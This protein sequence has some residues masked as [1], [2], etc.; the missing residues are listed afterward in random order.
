MPFASETSITRI[1]AARWRSG[2]HQARLGE[3]MAALIEHLHD[4]ARETQLTERE[5]FE[6]TEFL[7]RVGAISNEKRKEFILLSDTLGLSMLVELMN[8]CKPAGATEP[9]LLGP[10]YIPD[11]PR[12]GYGSRLPG[13][14]D[15]DGTP[16]F[17]TGRVTDASGV[18]IDGATLDI[19]QTDDKGIYEAQLIGDEVRH[20]GISQARADGSYLVRTVVPADYPIPTDGP[21]GELLGRTDISEYR[22]S[23]IHFKV[24]A[25]GFETLT[26][27][28]F[29][30]ASPYLDHDVVFGTRESLLIDL[31][32][33]P[34]GIAPNGDTIDRRYAVMQY[35]FALPRLMQE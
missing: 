5:W 24:S 33:R 35:D 28:L 6:A 21:V 30:R 18:P 27:H 3:L 29:D 19:W 7:T 13:V 22:P 10:F 8:N 20:R 15:A 2:A 25:P 17:L 26:T 12:I 23:H 16:L 31:D 32:H 9:T 1:A 11:S 4:F 14:F 34:A